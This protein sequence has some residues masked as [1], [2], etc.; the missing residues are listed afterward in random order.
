[1]KVRVH[2]RARDPDLSVAVQL[3]VSACR[4]A[5]IAVLSGQT[6]LVEQIGSRE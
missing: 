5:V 4:P 6:Y 3:A 2:T 1:M